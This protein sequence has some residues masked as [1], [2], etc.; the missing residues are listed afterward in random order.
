MKEL[1]LPIIQGPL[2]EDRILSMDEYIKFVQFNLRYV[3]KKRAYAK[4]EKC[5]SS[6]SHFL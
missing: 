3:F 2:S 5:S 1:N 6:M 4:W